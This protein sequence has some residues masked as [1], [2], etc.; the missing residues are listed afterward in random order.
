MKQLL[1]NQNPLYGRVDLTILLEAMDYYE[2]S[3]FYSS[4][5]NEDK[6][7]LYSVFGGIPYYN[8]LIDS[9]KSVKDNIIELIASQNSRLKNEIEQVKKT[10]LDCYRYGLFSKTGFDCKQ[11]E[12]RILKCLD[13]LYEF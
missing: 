11:N 8:R 7:K 1:T 3:L 6:V 12:D 5:S 13:E 4:F 2:S 10:G 9:K